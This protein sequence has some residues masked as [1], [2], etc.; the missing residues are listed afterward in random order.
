MQSNVSNCPAKKMLNKEIRKKLF[1][2]SINDL[3]EL[4]E[5]GIYLNDLNPHGQSKEMVLA[6]WQH[7][8]K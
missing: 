2:F 5:L 7:N 6:G 3:D 1:F 4:P 8:S